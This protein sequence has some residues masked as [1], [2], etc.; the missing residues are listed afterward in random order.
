M[1]F[2]CADMAEQLIPLTNYTVHGVASQH[3]EDGII[4]ECLRRLSLL[5]EGICVDVGASDG[6]ECSNTLVLR[7]VYGWQRVLIESDLFLFD[8]LKVNATEL[9]TFLLRSI[10]PTGKDSID[11]ILDELGIDDIH[12]LSL[13]VDGIDGFVL[14]QLKRSPSL[15]CA[16]FNQTVPWHLTLNSPSLGMSLSWLVS[17]MK[18]KDYEFIGATRINAFFVHASRVD[19]FADIDRN[20]QHY[21]SESEYTYLVSGPTGAIIAFGPQS[22]GTMERFAG[23]LSLVTINGEVK[24][25][26]VSPNTF[27]PNV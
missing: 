24:T 20:P 6:R 12:L 5:Q 3:G 27:R 13:D 17:L 18:T 4:I 15:L 21:L 11:S 16:E 8:R 26:T 22:F 14:Q 1:L 7:D 9:D 25:L 10:T 19:E 2:G 23:E